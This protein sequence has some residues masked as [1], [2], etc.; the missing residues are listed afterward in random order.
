MGKQSGGT[1]KKNPSSANGSSVSNEWIAKNKQYMYT[2]DDSGI[3]STQE[4]AKALQDAEKMIR[5]LYPDDPMIR[6][7]SLTEYEDDW[8]N[9]TEKY[10]KA[11]IGLVPYENGNYNPLFTGTVRLSLSDR[12]F[13]VNM[14]GA[15]FET[16]TLK[17]L[18]KQ[19]K[20]A[21]LKRHTGKMDKQMEDI[22]DKYIPPYHSTKEMDRFNLISDAI[23]ARKKI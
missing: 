15:E 9:P 16:A 7:T 2:T 8:M 14:D 13:I 10:L 23:R 21:L 22:M 20:Y 3:F 19:I 18:D 17:G 5:E 4:K 6:I 1:K 11:S 12:R